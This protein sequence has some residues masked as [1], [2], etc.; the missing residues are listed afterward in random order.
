LRETNFRRSKTTA[1]RIVAG[2]RAPI[3]ATAFRAAL[4]AIDPIGSSAAYER[5]AEPY[6]PG[7]L[8]SPSRAIGADD[9][10]TCDDRNEPA[11]PYEFASAYVEVASA[12][13]EPLE[14]KMR[15]SASRATASSARASAIFSSAGRA[16]TSPA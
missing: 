16:R 14:L 13:R 8:S 7:R 5:A 15:E 4:R 6:E 3:D 2:F 12:T 10:V 11:K 1:Q 9:A